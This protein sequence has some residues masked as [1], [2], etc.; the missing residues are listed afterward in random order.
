M[1]LACSRL[2]AFEK[3]PLATRL[4][5]FE[6]SRIAGVGTK[7]ERSAAGSG[8]YLHLQGGTCPAREPCVC[9]A[10]LPPWSGIDCAPSDSLVRVLCS[11][12]HCVQRL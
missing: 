5:A 1:I 6:L 7:S 2:A 11:L 9:P 10:H 4:A 12:L 8:H 3:A